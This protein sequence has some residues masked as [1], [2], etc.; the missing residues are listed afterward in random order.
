KSSHGLKESRSHST[1]QLK[2]DGTLA[3][4][5]ALYY[6]IEKPGIRLGQDVSS[7]LMRSTA[8]RDDIFPGLMSVAKAKV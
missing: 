4:S 6:L 5:A 2:M 1:C 7:W 8:A 3:L